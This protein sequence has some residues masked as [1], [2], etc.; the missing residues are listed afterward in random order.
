MCLIIACL[1]AWMIKRRR[2]LRRAV[3]ENRQN[4]NDMITDPYIRIEPEVTRRRQ[5]QQLVLS[6]FADVYSIIG[7]AYLNSTEASQRQNNRNDSEPDSNYY[8]EIAAITALSFVAGNTVG[9]NFDQNEYAEIQADSE[10]SC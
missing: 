8:S 4:T 1:I 9:H 7:P 3:Y 6:T 10:V 2:L 5:D